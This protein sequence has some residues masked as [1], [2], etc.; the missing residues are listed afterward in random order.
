[1]AGDAYGGVGVFGQH[2]AH[3]VQH[4]VEVGTQLVGVGVEGDIAGH[5]QADVVALTHHAHARALQLFAQ[6]LFL[7]VHVG[8][9]ARADDTAA[10][11]GVAGLLGRVHGAHQAADG[12]RAQSVGGGLAGLLLAGVGVGGAG[13]QHGTGRGDE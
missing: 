2:Q 8:A 5:D 4:R 6:L 9:H 12:C 7:H 10:Q 13:D 11:G 3:R 1:M